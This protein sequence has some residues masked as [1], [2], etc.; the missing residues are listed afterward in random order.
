M[1]VVPE[2]KPWLVGRMD[3]GVNRECGRIEG[4]CWY[5]GC[6][7]WRDLNWPQSAQ[8]VWVAMPLS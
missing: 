8:S 7:L 5:I 1:G 4:V 3:L 6:A 2:A